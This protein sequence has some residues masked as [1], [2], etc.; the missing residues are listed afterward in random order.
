MGTYCQ[1]DSYWVKLSGP[2]TVGEEWVELR[3]QPLLKAEKDSQFIVLDLEPPFKDDIY[4]EG[5]GTDSGKGVLMP[6][7]VVINPEIEVIDQD[8]NTFNL[9]WA[10][11]RRGAPAYDL[12]YPNKWPQDRE[13]KAVR[14]RSLR[15]IKFKAIHWYCESMKDRH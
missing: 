2:V 9:V 6:D 7:G 5:R 15:P 12:K 13:Y 10:G 11:T 8:N 14:I 3:P 1:R 4:K